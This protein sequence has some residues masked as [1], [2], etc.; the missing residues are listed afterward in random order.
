MRAVVPLNV[1][2]LRVVQRRRQRPDQQLRRSDRDVRQ[3]AAPAGHATA[4]H[5]RP[6]LALPRPTG[7]GVVEAGHPPALGAAGVL[8]ARRAGSRPPAG[9]GSRPH[10]TAGWSA[11][12]Y[13]SRT[14]ATKAWGP[15]QAT[16]WIVESDYLTAQPP[17]RD[18]SG[19]TRLPVAVPLQAPSSKIPYLYM[20]RV[21]GA[22]DWD[23]SSTPTTDYLP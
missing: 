4:Q 14:P 23:P 5:R 10:R 2:G 11:A 17:T 20:G 19:V 7:R 12:R 9:S 13:G 18:P 15:P 21:L 6:D 22:A 3:A 16:A 8:Q 1:A